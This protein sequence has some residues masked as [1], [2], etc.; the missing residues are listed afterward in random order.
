VYASAPARKGLFDYQRTVND[1][2]KRQF[3]ML[4]PAI[5]QGLLPIVATMNWRSVRVVSGIAYVA[6]RRVL[7]E[8][9]AEARLAL[10]LQVEFPLGHM[11]C[12]SFA[13]RRYAKCAP[14]DFQMSRDLRLLALCEEY[15]IAGHPQRPNRINAPIKLSIQHAIGKANQDFS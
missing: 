9:R 8:C 10:A 7:T 13:D 5:A 11:F 2:K 15:E 1:G 6:F 14:G 3:L 12:S 4:P